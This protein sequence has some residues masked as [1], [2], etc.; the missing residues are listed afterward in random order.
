MRAQQRLAMMPGRRS[1]PGDRFRLSEETFAMNPLERG[2][3][4]KGADPVAE[5]RLARTA[6]ACRSDCP[7]ADPEEAADWLAGWYEA[8]AGEPALAAPYRAN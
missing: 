4:G 8:A 3:A 1:P 7:Y 2:K 5:G 6:G